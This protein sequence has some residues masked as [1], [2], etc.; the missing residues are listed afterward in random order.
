MR[1]AWGV[2]SFE[3]TGHRDAVGT[4]SCPGVE[5]FEVTGHRRPGRGKRDP[6][7]GQ[8]RGVVN[9]L[10]GWWSGPRSRRG[11]GIL[12]RNALLWYAFAGFHL[13]LAGFSTFQGE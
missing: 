10:G 7:D 8:C 2:E 12:L 3:V 1:L 4:R 6:P 9:T 13:L 5:S 11:P